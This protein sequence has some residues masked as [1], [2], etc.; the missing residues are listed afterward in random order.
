MSGDAGVGTANF[1]GKDSTFEIQTTSSVYSSAPMFFVTNT[2]AS[3]NLENFKFK[4]VSRI[5][6]KV[7]ATSE[8]GIQ[9]KWRNCHFKF[10]KSRYLRRFNC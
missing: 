10:D 6:L 2:A 4:Y 3:I 1:I 9:F 8:W 7:G 5:F